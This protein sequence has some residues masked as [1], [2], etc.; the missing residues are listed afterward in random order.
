[1]VA[2]TLPAD[3]TLGDGV[4]IQNMSMLHIRLKGITNA[5]TWWQIFFLQTPTLRPWEWGQ[6]VKIQPFQN[7]V[8]LHIKKMGITNA[9]TWQ[10][11]FCPQTPTHRPP[12]L[13]MGSNSTF[14][15][16]GNVAYQIQTDH[17]CSNMVANILLADFPPPHLPHPTL[18]VKRSKFNF[19]RT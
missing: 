6:N 14:S 4:K 5:A 11:I 2:N 17:E 7:M 8:M 18:G 13:G 3:L 1:M 16:H 9:A 15:E 19:L 12:T 10:R